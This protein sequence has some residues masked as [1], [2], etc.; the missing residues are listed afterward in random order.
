MMIGSYVPSTSS[1]AFIH[2]SS[3]HEPTNLKY[4]GI[5]RKP[6]ESAFNDLV[7]SPGTRPGSKTKKPKTS[8][9]TSTYNSAAAKSN[10]IM[11][12]LQGTKHLAGYYSK[13][14]KNDSTRS[15]SYSKRSQNAMGTPN[16]RTTTGSAKRKK[17]RDSPKSHLNAHAPGYSSTASSKKFLAKGLGKQYTSMD[18]LL[19]AKTGVKPS[20]KVK[21]SKVSSKQSKNSSMDNLFQKAMLDNELKYTYAGIGKQLKVKKDRSKLKKKRSNNEVGFLNKQIGA[22]GQ[23][24]NGNQEPL[25]INI[26]NTN[27]LHLSNYGGKSGSGGSQ[28]SIET[29]KKENFHGIIKN[30]HP[31]KPM[32]KTTSASRMGIEN[33]TKKFKQ[34][35]KTT[36]P[37]NSATSKSRGMIL[38]DII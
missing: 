21:S 24:I 17:P 30:F 4:S 27:H 35:L 14:K 26:V 22:A 16:Q 37:K 33:K 9:L 18:Y 7:Y 6:V 11:G 25:S 31:N 5:R 23:D 12:G 34:E 15:G 28:N 13:N 10:I 1:S 3:A 29:E 2:K 36:R 38:K 19:E 32:A 20:L 8:S